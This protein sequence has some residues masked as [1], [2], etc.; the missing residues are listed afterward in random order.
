MILPHDHDELTVLLARAFDRAWNRYY[1]P[2]R[3]VTVSRELARISLAKHLINLAK[4]G[5]W[6]EEGLA[7]RGLAHLVA[8]TPEPWGQV[9]IE[10]VGA[11]FLRPWRVRI[12]R[13]APG[14]CNGEA[15]GEF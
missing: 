4:E 12:D 9:L 8:I 10:H 2:S 5:V 7:E 3:I 13:L 15:E 14:H 11:R 1:R 6:E